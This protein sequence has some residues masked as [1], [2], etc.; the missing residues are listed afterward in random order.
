MFV[1][2]LSWAFAYLFFT[3]FYVYSTEIFNGKW[4]KKKEN[5]MA[6]DPLNYD[7]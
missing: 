2:T 7:Q 4:R 3:N 5:K 1:L 6:I